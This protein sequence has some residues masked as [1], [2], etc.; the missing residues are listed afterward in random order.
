MLSGYDKTNVMKKEYWHHLNS[1]VAIVE[2]LEALF[3]WEILILS[4]DFA[5]KKKYGNKINKLS[6]DSLLFK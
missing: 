3:V 5:S 6:F 4:L 1:N 2:S